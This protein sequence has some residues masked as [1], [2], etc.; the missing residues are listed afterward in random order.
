MEQV[1]DTHYILTYSDVEGDPDL[2]RLYWKQEQDTLIKMD[3]GLIKPTKSLEDLMKQI[4]ND[5]KNQD[6]DNEG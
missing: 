5:L 6:L 2:E 1:K 4:V 3:L